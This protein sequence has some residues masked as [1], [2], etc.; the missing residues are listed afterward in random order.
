M[1]LYSKLCK[2]LEDDLRNGSHPS[3][4][5]DLVWLHLEQKHVRLIDQIIHAGDLAEVTE[6]KSHRSQY[7]RIDDEDLV[8]EHHVYDENWADGAPSGD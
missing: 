5:T 1:N 7:G 2:G 3:E 8:H 6:Q 4:P